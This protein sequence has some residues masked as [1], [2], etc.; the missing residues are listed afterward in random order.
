MTPNLRIRERNQRGSLSARLS[1]RERRL[2]FLY[3]DEL[4]RRGARLARPLLALAAFLAWLRTRRRV[5]LGQAWPQDLLAY[6]RTLGR[7]SPRRKAARFGTVRELFRFLYCRG[8][9]RHDPCAVLELP[10]RGRGARH[11]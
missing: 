5:T 11:V 3:E 6:R 1:R 8:L 9:L 10:P 7:L 4:V 2:L